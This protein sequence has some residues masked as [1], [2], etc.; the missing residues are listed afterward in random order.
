MRSASTTRATLLGHAEFPDIPD[1]GRVGVFLDW[2]AGGPTR[3]HPPS[4]RGPHRTDLRRAARTVGHRGAGLWVRIG[5][6]HAT[7]GEQ[8][9]LP[10]VRRRHR[11]HL[12]PRARRRRPD[13]MH[14]LARARPAG[15]SSTVTGCR[16]GSPMP[17]PGSARSCDAAHWPDGT[18]NVRD[19]ATLMSRPPAGKAVD[20][21]TQVAESCGGAVYGDPD[22]GDIVFKGQDW[23][24]VR[25][26]RRRAAFITN[27]QPDVD[28]DGLP[29][30]CPSA[31][32]APRGG[33]D[34]MT[35]VRFTSETS[36]PRTGTRSSR[37]GGPR[38]PKPCTGS[39]CTN[40]PCCASPG[41][42]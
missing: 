39:S 22:T 21:L 31:G 9:V 16:T 19:D 11:P 38:R 23:Q 25:R 18:A 26:R 2:G 36:T 13:R 7:L 5:V 29:R 32:N 28:I 3:R 24:G 8:L 40:A 4:H 37:S 35:R 17:R 33:A 1:G 10:G 34:M 14:R 30:V 27:C 12:P 6:D 20:L 42:G 41:N 15:C